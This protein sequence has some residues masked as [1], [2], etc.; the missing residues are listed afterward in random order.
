M[1][2]SSALKMEAGISLK[3]LLL[4]V[5]LHGTTPWKT[6]TIVYFCSI[7]ELLAAYLAKDDVMND[8][9]SVEQNLFSYWVI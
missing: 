7:K 3:L 1:T 5:S 8:S 6:V 2:H 9:V 4:P